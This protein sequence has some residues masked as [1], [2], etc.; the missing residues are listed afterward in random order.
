[1]KLENFRGSLEETEQTILP[2]RPSFGWSYLDIPAVNGAVPGGAGPVSAP[3]E[4]IRAIHLSNNGPDLNKLFRE[5]V[6][7]S[8][9][10]I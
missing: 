3:G 1:M 9:K 2:N 7:S 8:M 10:K 6:N 5:K 4:H